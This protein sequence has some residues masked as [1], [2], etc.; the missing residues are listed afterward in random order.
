MLSDFWND[1]IHMIRY[2]TGIKSYSDVPALKTYILFLKQ[3]LSLE[4]L[5]TI[6]GYGFFAAMRLLLRLPQQMPLDHLQ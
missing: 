2:C 5:V 3:D 6:R 4:D 1:C